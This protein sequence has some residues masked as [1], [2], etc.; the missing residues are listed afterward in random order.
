M[1]SPSKKALDMAKSYSIDIKKVVKSHGNDVIGMFEDFNK[2][3]A[4]K[5]ADPKDQQAFLSAVV[6]KYRVP[7]MN[8]FAQV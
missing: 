3:V 7:T 8:A 5:I 6:G 4:T 2:Q 1:A